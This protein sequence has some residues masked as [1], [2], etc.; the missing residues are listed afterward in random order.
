MSPLPALRC[1]P[2][3]RLAILISVAALSCA[4]CRGT[5]D[6]RA[7]TPARQTRTVRA[8]SVDGPDFRLLVDRGTAAE[9]ADYARHIERLT[10]F[11]SVGT[12]DTLLDFAGH[13]SLT[14]RD[15]E[16]LTPDALASRLPDRALSVRFLARPRDYAWRKLVRLAIDPG[17]PAGRRG[18][19]AAYVLFNVFQPRSDAA[20]DPFEACA[21]SPGR[22]SP[23]TQ[24]MLTRRD[25][26]PG[27]D[28]AFWLAF[29]STGTGAARTD[30]LMAAFDGG[31]QAGGDARDGTR[32]YYLPGAC[33]QC[34]GG[35]AAQARLNLLDT[36][37]WFDRVEHDEDVAGLRGASRHGVLFDGGVDAGSARFAAVLDV[38]AR[39]NRHVRDQN[40]RVGGAGFAL[41]AVERWLALHDGKAPHPDLVMRALPPPSLNPAARQWSDTP[42]D[43]A[44]LT[45]LNRHCAACHRTVDF[46]VF[47]KEAVFQRRASMA[48]RVELG[49]LR[50]GGMPQD[51]SLDPAVAA[52]IARQLRAM[53]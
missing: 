53:R 30:H 21:A 24:V 17:S 31:D 33:A 7:F 10:G 1:A 6:V 18:L 36:H 43:R 23:H 50:P 34:H 3:I 12:L 9:A 27:A 22:C 39:L 35:S 49:P 25:P 51:R 42:D 46:H 4:G 38:V 20:A 40:A 52:E 32:P 15:L 29:G 5:D 47:D 44:L 13:G 28:A 19:D 8:A 26:A 48:R 16:T 14:A 2:F 41:R 11:S 37:H 45:N